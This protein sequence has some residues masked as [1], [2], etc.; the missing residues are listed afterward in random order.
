[1]GA[2]GWNYT[3]AYDPDPDVALERLRQE[4]F[5]SGDYLQ[6]G[7]IMRFPHLPPG[8][9]LP[10]QLMMAA[11]RA[12]AALSVAAHWIAR[13]GRQPRSI[14]E[15]LEMTGESGT[16]SILDITHTA[17]IPEFGAATPL[18][19]H[20]YLKYFGTTTPTRAQIN[21]ASAVP[22]ERFDERVRRWEA[23]YVIVHNES[24]SPVEYV[25]AGASG[26]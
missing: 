3:T 4:I 12:I 23:V 18:S 6:P 5:A 26:D 10:L 2:T 17:D 7:G 22:G 1:M 14:D 20:R 25:F 9:P 11:L 21:A 8:A 19:K 24:G 16:H 13:G 15:L